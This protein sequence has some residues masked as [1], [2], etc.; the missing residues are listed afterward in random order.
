MA[1]EEVIEI[2]WPEV[3]PE[4]GRARLRN[5]LNRLRAACGE[6]VERTPDGLRLS[7]R[8]HVDAHRFATEA[9]AVQT[10]VA[11]VRPGRARAAL[12]AYTGE[13]L[14]DDRY[15]E[16]S[17]AARDGLRRQQLE[18]LHL[19]VEDAVA[20]GE[21]DEAVRLLERAAEAEPLDESW[22]I[23]AAELLLFQG[24][25]GSARPLVERVVAMRAGAGLDPD[26]RLARLAGAVGATG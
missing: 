15:A 6:L 3:E 24:R 22:P 4:T 12:A 10:A 8:A 1:A 17:R 21:L 5:L 9:A 16:W 11:S 23:R 2:L 7:P 26:R 25:R 14:P 13:L 19:L 18:L 20:R